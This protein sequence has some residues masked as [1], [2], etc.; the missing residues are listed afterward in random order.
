MNEQHGHGPKRLGFH[1]RRREVRYDAMKLPQLSARL[2][3]GP[4][5]RLLDIS[6]RGALVES[7]MLLRPGQRVSLC[8]VTPDG[9]VT[10]TG[11]AVRTTVSALTETEL[12]YRTG[13]SFGEDNTLYIR[14]LEGTPADTHAEQDAPPVD[15]DQ[16]RAAVTSVEQNANEL[17]DPLEVN[18]W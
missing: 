10:L 15:A 14:L 13:L 2:E 16:A 8:F 1:E 12:G 11:R 9:E 5:V 7:K 4:A 6:R 3:P 18:D 17:R